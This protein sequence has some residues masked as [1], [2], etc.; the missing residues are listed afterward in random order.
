MK[1]SLILVTLFASMNSAYAATSKVSGVV[2][3]VRIDQNGEG[4]IT[5]DKSIENMASCTSE[6]YHKAYSFDANTEG[7][8]AIYAMA[9]AARTTSK[10]MTAYGIGSC[11]EY[12]DTVES[13]WYGNM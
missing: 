10:P 6:F 11:S 3:N 4:I 2:T 7:G 1:K 8:K 5:F 9:L 13:I 12:P